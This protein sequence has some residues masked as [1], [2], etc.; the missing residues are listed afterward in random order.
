MIAGTE[1]ANVDFPQNG[2]D[3]DLVVIASG[4]YAD[5]ASVQIAAIDALGVLLSVSARHSD[6]IE[7]LI[8]PVIFDQAFERNTDDIGVQLAVARLILRVADVRPGRLY[9]PEALGVGMK[10]ISMPRPRADPAQISEILLVALAGIRACFTNSKKDI[11]FSI[12]ES[13]AGAAISALEPFVEKDATIARECCVTI[14]SLIQSVDLKEIL[15]K[16]GVVSLPFRA[17]KNHSTEYPRMIKSFLSS[18]HACVIASPRAAF[19]FAKLDAVPIILNMGLW[20]VGGEFFWRTWAILADACVI[21]DTRRL[22]VIEEDIA[23]IVD[24]ID[25]VGRSGEDIE[26][27]LQSIRLIGELS[28]S[29]IDL[30]ELWSRLNTVIKP[31]WSSVGFPI[32]A[33]VWGLV[34]RRF[35]HSR[36][37]R[38]TSPNGRD[39]TFALS[40][41]IIR[42]FN[43]WVTSGGGNQLGASVARIESAVFA[44]DALGTD[45]EGDRKKKSSGMGGLLGG[46]W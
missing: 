14:E 38:L 6:R 25:R 24:M 43:I 26:L 9:L 5:I 27:V 33:V 34:N 12:P 31:V 44:G 42:D 2:S 22:F 3:I 4:M 19:Q 46:I 39:L 28:V 10:I 11:H 45:R 29:S 16:G 8:P 7:N 23:R 20:G 35:P 37:E 21:D 1:N 18:L 17:V 30:N 40:E 36:F 15:V 32:Q 13:V 41:K